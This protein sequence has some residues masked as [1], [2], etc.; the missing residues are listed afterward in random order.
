MTQKPAEHSKVAAQPQPRVGVVLAAGLGSRLADRGEA[1]TPKPVIPLRRVP[2]LSRTLA[3]LQQAGC[4]RVVVVVGHQADRVRR[5]ILDGYSGPIELEFVYNPDYRLQ[6]GISVLCAQPHVDGE[7]VLTMA[8]HVFDASIMEKVRDHRPPAG[9]ATLCVDY[10]VDDIFDI[11]DA[12]KVLAEHGKIQAIGK[13]LERYNCIDTGIF[14]CTPA[15]ME[16]LHAVRQERGDAS[17]SDGVQRLA[18]QGKMHV[19]DIEDAFWQDVDTPQ[20]LAH[21]EE[22]LARRQS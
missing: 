12:T 20:M 5:E 13:E 22:Q 19:L 16:A 7:M 21:A 18:S 6:N 1:S 2:L 9:G 8:D 3:S 4:Q 15:L 17:L 11:D 14:I 10:K